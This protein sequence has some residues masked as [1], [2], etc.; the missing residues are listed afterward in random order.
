LTITHQDAIEYI[1]EH[2]CF[3]AIDTSGMAKVVRSCPL[4]YHPEDG[5][6][7]SLARLNQT[8][9]LE[10]QKN[11]RVNRQHLQHPDGPRLLPSD[12]SVVIIPP[13][14]PTSFPASKPPVSPVH[15]TKKNILCQRPHR[16]QY[17]FPKGED[18]MIR[19]VRWQS[20]GDDP[21]GTI[22]LDGWAD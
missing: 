16:K 4:C 20:S 17:A 3:I 1:R 13:P 6:Q 18:A 21:V 10:Q 19:D 5:S 15:I 14:S 9:F 7:K 12:N 8:I 11:T 22:R 2:T